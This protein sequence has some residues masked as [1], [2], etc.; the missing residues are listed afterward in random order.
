LR[1]WKKALTRFSMTPRCGVVIAAILAAP[2]VLFARGPQ[3]LAKDR[4][5]F[6]TAVQQVL[7]DTG[8]PGAG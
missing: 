1:I 2:G 7:N 6:Q 5:E 3:I 4:R 8:V